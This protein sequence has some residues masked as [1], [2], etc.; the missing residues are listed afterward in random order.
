MGFKKRKCDD[1]PIRQVRSRVHTDPLRG[2]PPR[3][4]STL[5]V[6]GKTFEKDPWGALGTWGD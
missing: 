3:S 5:G 6:A 2:A 4:G 1:P